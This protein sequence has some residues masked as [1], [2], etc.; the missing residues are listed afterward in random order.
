[1]KAPA[2]II[3]L[4]LVALGLTVMLSGCKTPDNLDNET[5][6]PWNAPRSWETGLPGFQNERR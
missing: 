1:M 2:R 4:L 5:S 3:L 6:R